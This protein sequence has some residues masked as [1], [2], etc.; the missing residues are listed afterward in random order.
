MQGNSIAL[1]C[2]RFDDGVQEAATGALGA[3]GWA[4]VFWQA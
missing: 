4:A 1:I 3:I 2:T